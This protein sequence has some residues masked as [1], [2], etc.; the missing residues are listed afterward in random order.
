MRITCWIPKAKDTHSEYV[1]LTAFSQQQS[2][3]LR[4][5][6]EGKQPCGGVHH[7][8]ST[9]ILM[10]INHRGALDK[11]VLSREHTGLSKSQSG[12]ILGEF[13]PQFHSQQF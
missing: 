5:G 3:H 1:T 9:L 7:F 6:R 4:V 12:Y 13:T 8:F 11:K 10:I 2:L